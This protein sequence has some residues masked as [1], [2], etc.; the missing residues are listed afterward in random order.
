MFELA[1]WTSVMWRSLAMVT[2]NYSP[3]SVVSCMLDI[4]AIWRTYQWRKC[5]PRQECDHES[6]PGEEEYP[7]ILIEWVKNGN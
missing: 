4:E 5:I 1:T 7:S 6:E 2:D 3:L